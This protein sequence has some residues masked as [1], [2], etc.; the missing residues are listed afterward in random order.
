MD[1]RFH[2]VQRLFVECQGGGAIANRLV[3]SPLIDEALRTIGCGAERRKKCLAKP[4]TGER[5]LVIARTHQRVTR[6]PIEENS[7]SQG[8]AETPFASPP[9]ADRLCYL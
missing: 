7:N 1:I 4:V 6:G 3:G 5:A 9:A 2:H 8:V